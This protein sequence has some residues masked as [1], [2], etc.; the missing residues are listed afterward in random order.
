LNDEL[1]QQLLLVLENAAYGCLSMLTEL[2]ARESRPGP[3]VKLFMAGLDSIPRWDSSVVLSEVQKLE[4]THRHILLYYDRV[5]A[6]LRDYAQSV[7]HL[8]PIAPAFPQFFTSFMCRFCKHPDVRR[9]LFSYVDQSALLRVQVAQDAFRWA[10]HDLLDQYGEALQAPR[11]HRASSRLPA[12]E[13]DNASSPTTASSF[14]EEEVR[15]TKGVDLAT[16]PALARS[17]KERPQAP[18]ISSPEHKGKLESPTAKKRVKSASPRSN[19]SPMSKKGRLPLT[20][21]VLAAHEALES[22]EE[23]R[24]IVMAS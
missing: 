17:P 3:R 2:S 10:L 6:L 23:T 20:E 1:A 7:L 16:K 24:S 8:P 5:Y 4:A 19:T 11:R 9:H 12:I 13:E 15:A 22:E 21:E 14:H 18:Q